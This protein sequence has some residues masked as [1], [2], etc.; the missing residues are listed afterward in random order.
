[1]KKG[2]IL[3]AKDPCK[4]SNG[5]NALLVGK[6]YRA[7]D[8]Y[9]ELDRIYIQSEISNFHSFH[10]DEIDKYFDT[11]ETDPFQE[12][13]SFMHYTHGLILTNGEMWDILHEIEKLQEKLKA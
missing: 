12:F 3:V 2:M 1:M 10:F 5:V 13:F 9:D 6:E 11:P 4:M 8:V 7:M